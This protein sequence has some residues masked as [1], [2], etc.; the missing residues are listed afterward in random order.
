MRLVPRRLLSS[1]RLLSFFTLLLLAMMSDTLAAQTYTT[2]YSFTGGADGSQPYGSFTIDSSGNLYGTASGGGDLSCSVF[3]PGCGVVFKLKGRKLTVLHAFKGAPDGA[4]PRA[5]VIFDA[6]GNI[7][8]TTARGGNLCAWDP[9]NGCGTIFKIDSSGHE[10]VLYRFGGAGDGAA[11]DSTLVRDAAGNL[12]GTTTLEGYTGNS[13]CYGG[14][15]TIFKLSPAGKLT[16]YDFQGPPNDGYWPLAGLVTDSSGNM[17]GTT[18]FGGA[19]NSGILF[20]VSPKGGGITILHSFNIAS[21]DAANPSNLLYS[22]GKL[23]GP[24]ISGGTYQG[25]AVFEVST[26]GETLFYNFAPFQDSLTVSAQG[27]LV[28]TSEGSIYGTEAYGGTFEYGAIYELTAH[29]GLVTFHQFGGPPDG[30]YP[31]GGLSADSAGNIY[32]MTLGGG[33]TGAG[34]IFELIK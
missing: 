6:Q 9:T 30:Q 7:Y 24:A 25:G 22:E 31:Y 8:G 4:L 13:Q 16:S 29:G 10:T 17:Y 2:L 33:T 28:R 15:G 32:G 12:W 21:N 27:T 26:S 11:P 3:V 20:Q 34:A 5:N 1:R 14:C 19:D 23:F 18:E